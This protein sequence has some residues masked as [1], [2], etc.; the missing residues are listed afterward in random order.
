MKVKELIAQLQEF[1]QERDIWILY[2]TFFEME[3]EF[4]EYE[5]EDMDKIKKGDYVHE[6]W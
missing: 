5:E 4:S 2:D 3:P 1:D 6:T